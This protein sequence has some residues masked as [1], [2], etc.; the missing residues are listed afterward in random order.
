M[1][2]G[3][4]RGQ[5]WAQAD[6]GCRQGALAAFGGCTRRQLPDSACLARLLDSPPT[7]PVNAGLLA[8]CAAALKERRRAGLTCMLLVPLKRVT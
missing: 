5:V 6:G 3:A 2:A 1:L 8:R 4:D 7:V